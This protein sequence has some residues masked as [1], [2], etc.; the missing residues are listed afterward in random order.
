MTDPTPDDASAV[1]APEKRRGWARAVAVVLVTLATVY[2]LRLADLA[3]AT[4]RANEAEARLSA[5][6]TAMA[7]ESAALQTAAAGAQSD[8]AVESWAREE[9]GWAREGDRVLVVVAPTAT[10]DPS[11]DASTPAGAGENVL[12]RFL[13]WLRRAR[14]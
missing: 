10:P 11:A 9:R 13:A 8:A 4:R 2:V 1:R 3:I 14:F 5:E 7:A 6:V 12:Q